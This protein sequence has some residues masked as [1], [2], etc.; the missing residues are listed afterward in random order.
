MQEKPEVYYRMLDV[1]GRIR[2][3]VNMA[4]NFWFHKRQGTS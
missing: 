3:L 4:R 1:D 2:D